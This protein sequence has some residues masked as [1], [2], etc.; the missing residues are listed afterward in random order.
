MTNDEY[1]AL[2]Q[3]TWKSLVILGDYWV[4]GPKGEGFKV[5]DAYWA[6]IVAQRFNE[7]DAANAQCTRL[8]AV[9]DAAI[10]WHHGTLNPTDLHNIVD[11]AKER[12]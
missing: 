8:E 12:Q 6:D 9:V 4:C 10:K 1:V 5:P 11:A 2:K 7:L 3:L